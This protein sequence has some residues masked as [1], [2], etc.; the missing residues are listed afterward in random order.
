MLT[1]SFWNAKQKAACES[2]ARLVRSHEA[3]I[4]ILAECP[5]DDAEM[6]EALHAVGSHGFWSSTPFTGS[7]LIILTRLLRGSFGMVQDMSRLALREIRCRDGSRILLAMVHLMSKMWRTHNDQRK[8]A[9]DVIGD[10]VSHEGQDRKTIIVGDF[11]MNPFEEGMVNAN[12]FHALKSRKEVRMNRQIDRTVYT[13]FYNPTWGLLGDRGGRPPG[14]F[15][16]VGGVYCLFWNLFDQVLL[17]EGLIGCFD[18]DSLRI[19]KD[20]GQIS[21]LGRAG[22]NRRISDHLPIMFRMNL[23]VEIED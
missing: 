11:N 13:P 21:F 17:R 3:D 10:I 5:F 23:E 16:R 18:E 20:D 2:A 22:V 6:L 12:A 4:L 19:L 8:A 14:T 9:E 7:D 15:R 1:I